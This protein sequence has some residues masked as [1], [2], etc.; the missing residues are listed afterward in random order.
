[1]V[2]AAASQQE[3]SEFKLAT[4]GR[5]VWSLHVLAVYVWVLSIADAELAV[6]VNMNCCLSPF[7]SAL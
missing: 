6:C 7:V 4:W 3:R 2:S 5:S 1:M